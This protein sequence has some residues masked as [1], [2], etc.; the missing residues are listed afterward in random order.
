MRK[1][2]VKEWDQ[3]PSDIQNSI[4][5]AW[6][7]DVP[8]LASAVFARWWQ[9]ETWLRS[10]IYLELRAAYGSNWTE[11]LPQLPN[12][13]KRQ[14]KDEEFQYMATPDAQALLA[15]TDVADLLKIID[16]QWSLFEKSLLP[17]EVWK[18]RVIELRN[19][20][21]R[22][23]HCRRPNPDDLSR[24][25]QILRDL[26]NGAFEAAAAFNRQSLVPKNWEDPLAKAWVDCQHETAQ[27]LIKHA[28]RQ[29]HTTFQLK[30]SK[31]PW[32]QSTQ[33]MPPVS[34]K[35]G[36]VWHAK[37][38]MSR[39][40]NLR[41]FW[42]DDTW[43]NFRDTILLMCAANPYSLEL[44][45]SALED[46][47]SIADTIGTAFD[48]II[49]H[50]IRNNLPQDAHERWE[51]IN[52]DLDPRVQTHSIWSIIEDSTKSISIFGA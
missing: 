45:F 31:R 46:A 35:K 11:R 41:D 21:N 2:S 51:E 13:V 34:G 9:F 10:L 27:R 44:S 52:T 7:S 43:D 6:R 18:G 49:N 1:N 48:L 39:G 15:Y 12:N 47:V 20:R 42:E 29:Y 26:E 37:W 36:Y 3:L 14:Q 38:T 16:E 28:Q 40:L 24:L 32:V 25:E 22:I 17:K 23:G 30:C 19:I 5:A 8:P 33:I 50:Q 4:S